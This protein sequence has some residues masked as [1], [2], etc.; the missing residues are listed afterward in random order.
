MDP[1]EFIA[2]I[3]AALAWPAAVVVLALMFRQSLAK[4][5]PGLTRLKWKDLE[6][7]FKRELSELS[8]AAQ[9]AQLSPL[10]TPPQLPGQVAPQLPAT[11]IL[12]GEIE[13]VAEVSPRAV[14][15]LAWAAVETE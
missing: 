12:E 3:V 2:A 10:P 4:L 15:P 8:V 5:L 14:I 9:A 11:R 1:L 6:L 7:E 13:A